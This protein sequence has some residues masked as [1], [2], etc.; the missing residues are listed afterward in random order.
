VTGTGWVLTELGTLAGG[1]EQQPQLVEH[2]GHVH[3]VAPQPLHAEQEG[4][5]RLKL[6]RQEQH[7]EVQEGLLAGR[8]V[9]LPCGGEAE[10][11]EQR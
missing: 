6:G 4:H 10:G 9:G 7:L 2:Q 3:A 5:G 8:E 11:G 1:L